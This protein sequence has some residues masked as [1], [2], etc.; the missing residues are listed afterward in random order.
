MV[1]SVDLLFRILVESVTIVADKTFMNNIMRAIIGNSGTLVE[2]CGVIEDTAV[3]VGVG[4][5]EVEVTEAT[6]VT[7]SVVSA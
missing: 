6:A 1:D 3:L 5:T 2:G 7:E 4:V